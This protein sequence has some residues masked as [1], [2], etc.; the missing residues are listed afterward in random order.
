[1]NELILKLTKEKEELH[2]KLS[3]LRQFMT[4]ESF[5]LI[6]PVQQKLLRYQLEPMTQYHHILAA[7]IQ[8]LEELEDGNTT[9]TVHL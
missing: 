1:M 8:H 6:H 2:D 3:K 4:T 7:R 5:D 9:K